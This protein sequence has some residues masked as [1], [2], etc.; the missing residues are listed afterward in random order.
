MYNPL[1]LLLAAQKEQE[2]LAAKQPR[3]NALNH[4]L[5]VKTQKKTGE[6]VIQNAGKF[7]PTS[8][9]Y[10]PTLPTYNP[11]DPNGLGLDLVTGKPF[12]ISGPDPVESQT[13][14]ARL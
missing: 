14:G 6:T 13:T 4:P 8:P 2:G 3:E 12:S 5:T 7:K 11:K 9:T 10:K 1:S